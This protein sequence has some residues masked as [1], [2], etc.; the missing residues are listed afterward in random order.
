MIGRSSIGNPWLIQ[1]IV[2]HFEG[3]ELSEPTAIER[4]QMVK[5][6]YALLKD[7][8]GEKLAILNLRSLFSR[9]LKGL[10]VK[11]YKLRLMKITKEQEMN[12]L[13][14]EMEVKYEN[15]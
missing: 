9:Y 14:K 7:E 11:E 5:K 10:D 4:I 15:S 12:D 8:M 3:K 1:N 6:H 13:F 2:N